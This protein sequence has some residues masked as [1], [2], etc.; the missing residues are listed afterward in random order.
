MKTPDCAPAENAP[1]AKLLKDAMHV[2]RALIAKSL[3]ETPD[4]V[5]GALN[6]IDRLAAA[7][8]P[9]IGMNLHGQTAAHVAALH[10][11]N[12][13]RGGTRR[14]LRVVD[15]LSERRE[16]ASGGSACHRAA[17]Q[18]RTAPGARLLHRSPPT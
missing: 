3:T 6:R 14:L 9:L 7:P 11:G 18:E 10:I 15:R 12:A 8:D 16:R 17:G 2:Q 13:Q 1:F 4:H 5:V